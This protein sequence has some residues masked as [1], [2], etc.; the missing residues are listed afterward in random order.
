[1]ARVE[2]NNG[3]HQVVVDDPNAQ[4]ED[5]AR[6]A[7][8]LWEQTKISTNGVGFTPAVDKP[9]GRNPTRP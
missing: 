3:G 9:T 6:T 2:I 5:V 4:R 7:R 8:K 1:M